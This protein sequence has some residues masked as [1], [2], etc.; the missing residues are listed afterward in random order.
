MP[1]SEEF[2]KMMAQTMSDENE[3]VKPEVKTILQDKTLSTD[4]KL[5]RLD[6]LKWNKVITEKEYQEA[7]KRL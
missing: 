2:K 1:L 5:H 4:Q 7:I 6:D 3:E